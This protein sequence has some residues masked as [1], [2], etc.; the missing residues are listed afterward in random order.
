[1]ANDPGELS[2]IVDRHAWR[3]DAIDSWR[4][5]T[6]KRVSVVES[7]LDELDRAAEIAR[8]VANKEATRVADSRRSR[9]SRS[10]LAVGS[11]VAACAVASVVIEIAQAAAGAHP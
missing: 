4:D 3:L 7:R 11:L 6:D 1:M 9:F 2:R 8:A 5:R 10:E